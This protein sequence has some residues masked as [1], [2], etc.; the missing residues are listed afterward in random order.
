MTRSGTR[1]FTIVELTVAVTLIGLVAVGLHQ[2]YL[3]QR[4]FVSWQAD[5][6]RAHD[7]YRVAGSMI[8]ADLR[9]AAPAQGDLSLPKADSLLLRAPIGLAFVCDRIT[10]TAVLGLYEVAGAMPQSTAD[11]MLVYA[12][13]GWRA[14]GFV[15]TQT[16][17]S[18]A[19]VCDVGP[20]TPS[21]QIRLSPGAADNVPIGAPVRAFRRHG[22]HLVTN[23]GA[24]WLART[25]AAG[26]EPLVGPLMPGGLRFRLLNASGGVE[27]SLPL[28]GG[29][30]MRMILPRRVDMRTSAI[31]ADTVVTL[32][33]LR[34][35]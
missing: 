32:L 31:R 12:T 1:G 25:T 24:P 6:V 7:A 35:R 30:E 2:A 18:G 8:S 13:T 10:S 17:G 34:N 16:P 14:A 23:E 9:E 3:Q 19:L 29:V 15:A 11:S 5:G 27:T 26:T 4:L 33:H 20:A 21:A 22:Y 28:V